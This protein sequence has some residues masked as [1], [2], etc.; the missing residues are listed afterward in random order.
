MPDLFSFSKEA[1]IDE[2][3]AYKLFLKSIAGRP[4]L[5]LSDIAKSGLY[6]DSLS[7]ALA[8]SLEADLNVHSEGAKGRFFLVKLATTYEVCFVYYPASES[9]DVKAIFERAL[10]VGKPPK[11]I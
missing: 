1:I 9:I 11:R 8:L 6:S 4:A 5:T 10:R 3:H 7:D 2:I